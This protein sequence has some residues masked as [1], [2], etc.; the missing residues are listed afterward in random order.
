FASPASAVGF[1][2]HAA[3]LDFN[4]LDGRRALNLPGVSCTVA[5]QI[6]AL[7]QIAGN[8]VVKL[9]KSVPNPNIANIVMG[10]PENFDPQRALKLGFRADKDFAAIIQSYIDTEM[11]DSP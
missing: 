9:I 7:R 11:T 2:K 5:N 4:R 8:D 3:E 10:W 1:L 6:E